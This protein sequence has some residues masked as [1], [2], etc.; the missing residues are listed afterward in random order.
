MNLFL[1]KLC[2][3]GPSFIP[4]SSN[5]NCYALLIDLDN[6]RYKIRYKVHFYDT[7]NKTELQ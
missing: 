5:V 6:F 2:S 3:K 1:H 4:T 7:S